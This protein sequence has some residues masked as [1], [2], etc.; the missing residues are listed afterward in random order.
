M[1]L[2]VVLLILMALVA[3]VVPLFP[4]LI[5]RAHRASQGTN[6]SEVTKAI[7]L[8]QS[9]NGVYPDG[10]DLMTDGTT[11]INYMPSVSTPSTMILSGDTANSFTNYLGFTYPVGGY[12]SAGP[13]TAGGLAALNGAGIV[14]EYALLP[15]ATTAATSYAGGLGWTPTFNPYQ[16]DAPT[17]GAT[18]L[19]KSTA[20]IYVNGSGVLAAGLGNQATVSGSQTQFV[21][22][23]LGRRCSAIGT[24]LANAPNNFPNDAVHENPD[25]VYE[26]FG[27]I[28]QLEDAKGNALP[29]AIFLGAVAIESNLLLGTDKIEESYYQ[30]VPQAN[31]PNSGPGV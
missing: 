3:I 24:V 28:F 18:T 26:R 29:S 6:T 4:S 1:E 11:M 22:F 12:V 10:Y 30:N 27:L 19:S 7:Q 31:A 21:M 5:E 14:T 13:L 2:L 16:G 23:G 20:V 9:T 8:Y 17:L 25:L 15:D